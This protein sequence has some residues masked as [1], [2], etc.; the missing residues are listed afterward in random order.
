MENDDT[1]DPEVYLLKEECLS[2]L[3]MGMHESVIDRRRKRQ[4]MRKALLLIL[5]KR[6]S[7]H[8]ECECLALLMVQSTRYLAWMKMA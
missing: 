7:V 6:K 8:D 5:R 4:R 1:S 2:T 3:V